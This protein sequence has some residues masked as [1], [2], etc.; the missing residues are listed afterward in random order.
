MSLL[1]PLAEDSILK[2]LVSNYIREE[3]I[4]ETIMSIKAFVPHFEE[5]HDVFKVQMF[6]EALLH[7]DLAHIAK[8][9]LPNMEVISSEASPIFVPTRFS[10]LPLSSLF[11][12]LISILSFPLFLCW[13]QKRRDG[14]GILSGWSVQHDDSHMHN[15]MLVGM[16]QIMSH[17]SPNSFISLACNA[18]PPRAASWHLFTSSGRRSGPEQTHTTKVFDEIQSQ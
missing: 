7:T 4:K 17:S 13:L 10:H 12:S 15:N 5:C 14:C 3:W 9:C 8:G 11:S 16:H 18:G 2:R 1:L 6:L